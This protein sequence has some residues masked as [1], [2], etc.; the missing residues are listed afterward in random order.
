MKYDFDAEIVEVSPRDG[1][2]NEKTILGLD[3]KLSLIDRAIAAGARRIEV[4]SFVNPKRVP[5]MAD[6]ES[7]AA[8]LPRGAARYIGLALNRRGFDRVLAAGLDEVNFAVVL[9]ETFSARNQGMTTDQGIALWHE[10]GRAAEGRIGTGLTLAAA[11]GCPFEGDMPLERMMDVLTRA[12]D[13]MPAELTLADT[14]GAAVPVDI[15]RRVAAVRDRWPDLPIRLHL[16]NTRNTGFANAWAG[17]QAGVRS[18][19]AS[20]GGVGGCPFAPRATGNIATED[21]AWMLHR[22]RI[23]TGWNVDLACAA[24]AWLETQLGHEIPGMLMKAGAFPPAPRTT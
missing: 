14:I 1:I 6:A 16:H 12:L 7:L 15:T 20:L 10:V 8:A 11:F 23:D 9:S 22:S 2:Q 5:Q 3:A 17:I 13:V 19:D 21:L 18:F 4:T 24:A